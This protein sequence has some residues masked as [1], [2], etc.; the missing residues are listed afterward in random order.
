MAIMIS[1]YLPNDQWS[2]RFNVFD[3]EKP[4]NRNPVTP[5]PPQESHTGPQM[6]ARKNIISTD[7][8]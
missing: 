3:T 1:N 6:S 8:T 5:P 4:Y 7:D 2:I